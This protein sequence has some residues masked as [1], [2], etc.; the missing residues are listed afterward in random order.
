MLGANFKPQ[1]ITRSRTRL[2]FSPEQIDRLFCKEN[3]K[4]HFKTTMNIG[5]GS[6]GTV[7]CGKPVHKSEGFPVR[8][9]F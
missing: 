5:K 3:P 6:Y 9:E 1:L 4:E 7:H 2:D 8:F